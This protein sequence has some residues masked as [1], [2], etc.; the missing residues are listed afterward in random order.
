MEHDGAEWT[1][2]DLCAK[3]NGYCYDNEILRLVDVIPEVEANQ[4]EL[5]YP[6]FLNPYTYEVSAQRANHP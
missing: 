1:Y 5:T 6:M 3:W 4:T 2:E